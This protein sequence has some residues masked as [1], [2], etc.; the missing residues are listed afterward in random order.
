MMRT[1]GFLVVT[2]CLIVAFLPISKFWLILVPPLGFVLTLVATVV[3]G[4]ASRDVV[5]RLQRESLTT[6]IPIKDL[7]KMEADRLE[8]ESKHK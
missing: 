8:A 2:A 5:D 6:G 4:S 1:Q 3:R 7:V